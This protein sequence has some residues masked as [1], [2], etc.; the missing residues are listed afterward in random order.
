MKIIIKLK[1]DELLAVVRTLEE[2]ICHEMYESV[3]DALV[4]VMVLKLYKKLKEKS[5][6]IDRAIRI[7]IP[8]EYALS[9]VEFFDYNVMPFPPS[10]FNGNVL[11]RLLTQLNQQTADIYHHY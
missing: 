9:L 8:I 3:H 2:C 7:Q 5:I 10:S 6:L 1:P 4:N 11:H